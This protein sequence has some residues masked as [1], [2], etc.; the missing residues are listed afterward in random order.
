MLPNAI[1][2]LNFIISFYN[3]ACEMIN[4]S[5]LHYDSHR[6]LNFQLFVS[7][8]IKLKTTFRLNL[9]LEHAVLK[10]TANLLG[11]RDLSKINNKLKNSS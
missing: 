5:K 11:V 10:R 9:K 4:Y 7:N 8:V 1:K 3:Y 2:Y 6:F